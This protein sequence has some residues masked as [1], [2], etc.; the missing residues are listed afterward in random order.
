MKKNFKTIPNPTQ[1]SNEQI[2]AYEKGGIGNDHKS[3]QEETTQRF[4]LDMPA[5]LH[6]RLKMACAATGRK[7]GPEV[8]GLVEQRTAELER[9]ASIDHK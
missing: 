3:N 4:S 7:M 8:L 5:T 1:P 2:K 6:R 9:E